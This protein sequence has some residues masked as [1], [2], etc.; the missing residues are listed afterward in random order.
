MVLEKKMMDIDFI[1]VV[2][3]MNIDFIYVW[4]LFMY[5]VQNNCFLRILFNCNFGL[6]LFNCNCWSLEILEMPRN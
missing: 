5:S 2:R 4:I 3:M 6:F 1:H